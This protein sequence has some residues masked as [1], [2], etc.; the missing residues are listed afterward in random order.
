VH[1]S[2]AF[3]DGGSSDSLVLRDACNRLQLTGVPTNVELK[4][5]DGNVTNLST[6]RVSFCVQS[7][8]S[9][10]SKTM[11]DVLVVDSLPDVDPKHDTV[12]FPLH[13]YVKS[14][15]N[16][17]CTNKPVE[18]LI[19][20][21]DA[22]LHCMNSILH[23]HD[24][25]FTAETPLG[26]VVFG[27]CEVSE[28]RESDV[29]ANTNACVVNKRNALINFARFSNIQLNQ[30]LNHFFGLEF[31]DC[32]LQ[33]EY[34]CP[35]RNDD[36]FLD[37]MKSSIC[38]VDGHYQLALPFV[39]DDVALPNN[40]SYALKHL[41]GLLKRIKKAGPELFKQYNDQIQ[42]LINDS[43]AKVIDDPDA[44]TCS[45]IWYLVHFWVVTSGK[46]RVVFNGSSKFKGV[47]LNDV[48]LAGPDLIKS[49]VG[50]LLRFRQYPYA[51][52]A[53]LK[54]MFYQVKV[55]P[56]DQDCLRFLW[57]KNGDPSQGIVH[58]QMTVHAFGLTSSMTVAN[59]A[60]LQCALDNA[61]NVS[62]EA[63]SMVKNDFMVDDLLRSHPDE[64]GLIKLLLEGQ[65]LCETA[66]FHQTKYLSSSKKVMAALP[67]D[68]LS[69]GAKDVW[70]NCLPTKPVLGVTWDAEK[71]T[72]SVEINV[73]EDVPHTR[74]GI[75][76]QIMRVWNPFG[77]LQPFLLPMK[78]LLQELLQLDLSWDQVV[79][80]NLRK[81]WVC[82]LNYLHLLKSLTLP[83]CYEVEHAVEIQLHS[84]SDAS[85][86]GY[87]SCCYLRYC[88]STGF[89]LAF[90][91]GK[92]RV[93]G[94]KDLVDPTIPRLEL[95]SAVVSVR[96]ASQ[97]LISLDL[98]ISSTYYWSDSQTVLKYLNNAN[99]R[100]KVFEAN[101]VKF[102]CANTRLQDWYYVRSEQNPAD[103]GSRGLMPKDIAKI[104]PWLHGPSFLL[105]PDESWK[106]TSCLKSIC[107]KTTIAENAISVETCAVVGVKA[108]QSP[109]DRL[110]DA[111]KT[112]SWIDL[113]VAFAW[114]LRCRRRLHSIVKGT[115]IT[116]IMHSLITALD[117]E[118]TVPE[119]CRIVQEEC[120]PGFNN[121][122]AKVGFL[123][124]VKKYPVYICNG[125]TIQMQSLKDLTPFVSPDGLLRV[126]GRTQKSSFPEEV[127]HPILLPPRHVVTQLLIEYEHHKSDHFGGYR[128]VLAKTRLKFWI[129][130]G[131]T[132]VKHYLRDCFTCRHI[133]AQPMEQ[134]MAPLPAARFTVKKRVFTASAVDYLGPLYVKVNRSN[135]KRWICLFTCLATRC[136]HL[137][138]VHSLSTDSFIKAYLRFVYARGFSLR[139]LYSDNA[140]CFKGAD[141]ELK[142]AIA[143]LDQKKI[144]HTLRAHGITWIFHPPLA[145]HQAGVVERQ[146]RTV[147][148]VFQA[149][150]VTTMDKIFKTVQAKPYGVT[151]DEDLDTLLKEAELIINSRPLTP[152]SESPDDFAALTPLTIMTGILHPDAPVDEFCNNDVL[153][154]SLR[155]TQELADD[156]W[157]LWCADYFPLLQKSIKWH[158]VRENLKPGDLV[159]VK[160]DGV[161][162]RRVYPKALVLEVFKNTDGLVRR[163]S[164]RT[165]AGEKV[166]RDVRKLSLLEASPGIVSD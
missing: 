87:A 42:Q 128:Y 22:D 29:S 118:E 145:S 43:H 35:S 60:K 4:T 20:I 8:S 69:N 41:L 39:K 3:L 135:Q 71:D 62:D 67:Q 123:D 110:F 99:G 158:K 72:F 152:I 92:S 91:L 63:C 86:K 25:V 96:L 119:I 137:E 127:K 146:V 23:V 79:P 144:C 61:V 21:R 10:F 111:Y 143:N 9:S 6:E 55:P 84:F 82:W 34:L 161:S 129:M 54:K 94:R 101:R 139:T 68:R 165:P 37:I 95:Q 113:Q 31:S 140:T 74:K 107:G 26:R 27:S 36:R 45:R 66:G 33:D 78:I 166:M 11:H 76:S 114:I 154:K 102:I 51:A 133:K 70:N 106:E 14:L 75:L 56:S 156:F 32:T 57:F 1:D 105:Q 126:G 16:L 85:K 2:T 53:D 64:D 103:I 148:K 157:E 12:N 112:K 124:A 160:E 142:Q 151:N 38:K 46:F 155:A 131:P 5:L 44:V 83:R 120:F 13:D 153:I 132:S 47:S 104:K 130:N 15:P 122:V 19:G 65:S 149:K 164:I 159:L 58:L 136:I 90:V 147:R 81:V 88:T 18:L 115:K 108:L 52:V 100:Y 77:H 134:M 109:F 50:I 141:S 48:L 28:F 80:E 73:D 30:Q 162:A 93:V 125:K 17:S 59:Y 163:A 117:M 116:N 138:K 24:N 49:L 98:T 40:Y 97:I 89:K 150:Q 7:M 121:A